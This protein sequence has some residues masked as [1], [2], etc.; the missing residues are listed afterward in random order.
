M[1]RPVVVM[2]V[3]LSEQERELLDCITEVWSPGRSRQASA[4]IGRLIRE[5]A[6]EM[7]LEV[8]PK[9]KEQEQPS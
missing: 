6:K 1:T 5:K 4:T 3:S 2:S 8:K 9:D 7:G